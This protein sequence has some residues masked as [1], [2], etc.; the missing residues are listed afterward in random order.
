MML[1]DGRALSD[2]SNEEIA[3]VVGAPAALKQTDFDVAIVGS[4]SAGLSAAGSIDSTHA[5]NT[6]GWVAVLSTSL[7]TVVWSTYAGN[8]GFEDVSTP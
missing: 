3:E 7:A 2:P 5:G 8:A 6:D 4:G 1:P